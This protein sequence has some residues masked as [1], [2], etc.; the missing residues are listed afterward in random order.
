MH[1]ACFASTARYEIQV[2]GRKL[3]GSA[4]R[5]FRTAALQHGS[6]LVGD[7]HLRILDYL[8]DPEAEA[9]QTELSRK[10][11][12]LQAVLGRAIAY[13]EVVRHLRQGFEA[14]FGIRLETGEPSPAERA[15]AEA[16]RMEFSLN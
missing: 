9:W 4:Q 3:V 2:G 12:C 16:A 5:R 11:T 10:T 7:E 1:E 15:L 13:D 8:R 14:A 6:V